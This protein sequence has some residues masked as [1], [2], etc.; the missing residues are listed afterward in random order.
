MY[1]Y[2]LRAHARTH[3]ANPVR[4]YKIGK[5]ARAA[6]DQGVGTRFSTRATLLYTGI[7]RSLGASYGKV[8]RACDDGRG[9]CASAAAA[10]AQATA[11][12]AAPVAQVTAHLRDRSVAV[13]LAG[14]TSFGALLDAV[15]AAADVLV[16]SDSVLALV[17][18]DATEVPSTPAVRAGDSD[19]DVVTSWEAYVA[20]GGGDFKVLQPR[21]SPEVIM[22][23]LSVPDAD[24]LPHHLARS[25]AYFEALTQRM[26][27]VLS[28]HSEFLR[29]IVLAASVMA[30]VP[31]HQKKLLNLSHDWLHTYLPHC[32]KKV[33]RV[34]FGLLNDGE[35]KSALTVD[36]LLPPSRLKLGVPFVGKDVPSQSS[37]F[38]HPDII[39]GLS[40]FAYRYQGLR[41]ADFNDLMDII[42]SNF[43]HEIGPPNDRPSSIMYRQWVLDAGG[44]IRGDADAKNDDDATVTAVE[45]VAAAVGG[46]GGSKSAEEKGDDNSKDNDA[47]D[48]KDDDD[49]ESKEVVDLKYLQRSNTEQMDKLYALWKSHPAV[50]YHYLTTMIFPK[51]M[52]SQHTKISACGQA[53]GGDMLFGRRVGF[54]GTP[55]DLLPKEMGQC[56]YEKGDD[57]K[58]MSTILNTS[59]FDVKHFAGEWTIE[60]LLDTVANHT[61]EFHALIDTGA[62]I[63]GYSNEEVAK[64]LLARG[65][66]G[67]DGVVFLDDEDKKKVLVRATGRIVNQD[68]C[69]IPLTRRFAFY[70]QIHTTG[71]DIKHRVNA[72]AALTLG[73]DM[74]FRDYVQGAY[75]MRGI[76]QG[77]VVTV[78]VIPEVAE[79]M[80][81]QL[82]AAKM[83]TVGDSVRAMPTRKCL[84]MIAAWL[85]I[86]SMQTEQIQ[87]TM[88][89]IQNI[90]N[91]YRK[92]AFA[93]LLERTADEQHA[94][95]DAA[96]GD[97]QEQDE[98]DGNAEADADAAAAT[99]AAAAALLSP[100]ALFDDA[101]GA[102][103]TPGTPGSPLINEPTSV[104]G[105]GEGTLLVD[106]AP[107]LTPGGPTALPESRPLDLKV[108]DEAIDFSLEEAVPDPVPFVDKLQGMLDGH[109]DFLKSANCRDVS[110]DILDEV[111][112][113]MLLD[114]REINLDTEQERE[115]E[116]EQQKEVQAKKDQQIEV[117]KFV[118]REYSR[119]KEAPDHWPVSI[120]G[121]SKAATAGVGLAMQADEDTLHPFYNM[122]TFRLRHQSSMIFP[123]YV[124]AS[125]N[126]FNRAWTG[127]RRLKNVIM[128][129]EWVPSVSAV[130]PKLLS[131]ADIQEVLARSQLAAAAGGGGGVAD[132]DD[133]E[134]AETDVLRKAYELL[135]FDG[136]S[137]LT[138][139]DVRN[140]I[141]MASFSPTSDTQLAEVMA[142]FGS[143]AGADGG[144]KV[145]TKT[146]GLTFASF[147]ALLESGRIFQQQTGR[148]WVAVNLSLIHI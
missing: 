94:A 79:L 141:D 37:E 107:L 34:S 23:A 5:S 117:E 8:V 97:D 26:H 132:A 41:R 10:A 137:H 16:H 81:R 86:S 24:W 138:P 9:V 83:L 7:L 113:F 101:A 93:S 134:G 32:M 31:T 54:S 124:M 51:H 66:K 119:T 91:L 145:A 27:R 131:D 80:Q 139:D 129:L 70:D 100:G 2:P 104:G 122:S 89:C 95:E 111:S 126:Y 64:E 85:I 52:R 125:T 87:W 114:G 90:A 21:H 78:F 19:G 69:G 36:P 49:A 110:Q 38:A 116:Q 39:L 60:F 12:V 42:T 102:P 147:R 133:K 15:G 6:Q 67:F 84:T 105:A 50:L 55:S 63:T 47:G 68:Q 59:I 65:L 77:Q 58:M 142:A 1:I 57:G 136:G 123:D 106:E 88:L 146:A 53:V 130:A 82:I 98:E 118:D 14:I 103:G 120:L 25:D 127:L 45:A 76:G 109:S 35:C 108:F 4:Y 72:R 74:V 71:M 99:A 30:K 62:L 46:G 40:I 75:R 56:D 61:P 33:N 44:R 43:T 20:G 3:P 92:T 135:S 11:V 73:K 96:E 128:I 140:A 115:Q 28:E 144:D 48:D 22:H 148:Y 18:P 29:K 112:R 143:V 17:A 121:D 13:D